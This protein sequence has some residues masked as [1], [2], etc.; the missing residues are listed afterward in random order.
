MLSIIL[1][2]ILLAACSTTADPELRASDYG[3]DLQP[4]PG[5][6]T[7]GGQPRGRLTKAPAGSAFTHEFRNRFGNSV[8]ERYVIQ[9]DRSLRIVSR[10]VNRLPPDSRD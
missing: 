3:T 8:S 9:P 6:I 7:Y 1:P 10:H 4:I 2:A 5:S